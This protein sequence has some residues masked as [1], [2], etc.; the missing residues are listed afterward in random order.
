MIRSI[1][2]IATHLGLINLKFLYIDY[3]ESRN[4]LKL[5]RKRFDLSNYKFVRISVKDSTFNK[6]IQLQSAERLGVVNRSIFA[7]TLKTHI[8]I[9]INNSN[10]F[11]P[12]KSKLKEN[13]LFLIEPPGY[14]QKLGYNQS[15]LLS[16]FTRVYTSDPSLYKQGGKFIACPPYVHWHL[17]VSSYNKSN[18]LVHDYDF[19]KNQILPPVKIVD[20]SAI[21]SNINHLPGHQKRA[22]F[23]RDLCDSGLDF[24][25]YGGSNW[26][27][28]P[29]YV[30]NAPDGK[31]PIF[32]KSRYILVIENEVAPF[33]WTEKIT[34]AILC[35]SMPIYFGC[36]NID[37]YLPEGSY[38]NFDI[39][40]DDSIERLKKI[41]KSD[42][43]EKNIKN[44]S[45][46]RTLILEKYNLLNFIDSEL[47]RL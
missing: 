3:I 23:I 7:T 46:A 29:Q 26:E 36:S 47:N 6:P 37:E 13:W 25:L 39:S 11:V 20:L 40:A 42:F 30:D 32:S 27:K 21:N 28:Y 34:D 17:E 8:N 24:K 16:K 15:K 41:L 45:K 35:W 31:W 5:L 38:I 14:V 33:Y 2:T 9:V 19:L 22:Q 18:E 1:K 44:L 10:P 43:Y 12:L 4:R